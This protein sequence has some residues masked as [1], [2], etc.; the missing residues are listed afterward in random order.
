VGAAAAGGR[1][2]A[3]AGG[4]AGASGDAAAHAAAV[5]Q[6]IAATRATNR[7][8]LASSN[9][10]ASRPKNIG[11]GAARQQGAERLRE[12]PAVLSAV[13][14]LASEWRPRGAV[15]RHPL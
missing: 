13:K 7:S 1:S 3:G 9:P 12:G 2:S 8:R 10:A 11:S 5:A 14:S 4:D 6:I 15:R